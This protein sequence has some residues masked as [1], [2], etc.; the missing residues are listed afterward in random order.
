ML[1]NYL[2]I[3]WRNLWKHKTFSLINIAGLAIGMATSLLILEYV[4]FERSFDSFHTQADKMYRI[5]YNQA[6]DNGTVTTKA[7]TFASV[8][9]GLQNTFPEIKSVVRLHRSRALLAYETKGQTRLF[10]EENILAADPSV[11]TFFSFPLVR[12]NATTSL[13]DPTSIVISQA[14]AQMYFGSENPIGKTL[15]MTGGYGDWTG[16]DYREVSYFTVTGVLAN[17]PANSHLQLDAL[18]SFRLFSRGEKELSNWGDS[19]HT[20]VALH[21]GASAQTLATKLP[22]FVKK[23]LGET[24]KDGL[25]LQPLTDIHLDAAL[26]GDLG[27]NGSRLMVSVLLAIAFFVSLIG[28]INYVNLTTARA[29]E[30][31]KE[32]GIRK[33]TGASGAN[34]FRQF[35]IESLFANGLGIGLAIGLVQL[36]QPLFNELVKQPLSLHLLTNQSWLLV[37]V[38]FFVG[39]MLCSGLYPILLNLT[40][41]PTVVL[42]GQPTAAG[43]GLSLRKGLVVFQFVLSMIL[44]TG[45]LVMYRQVT[46]MQRY[47]VGVNL[48]QLVLDGPE[49]TDSTYQT[50]LRQLKTDLLQLPA[51]KKVTVS[52]LIPGNPISGLSKAGLVRRLGQPNDA[53]SSRYYFSQVD[54]QFQQTYGMRLVAGQWFSP[55]ASSDLTSL[56][57]VVINKTAARLLGYLDPAKAIGQKINYRVQSTPTIIGVLD[58]YHQLSL[59]QS[60]APIIFELGEA[61]DG[62]YTISMNRDQLPRT[63]AAIQQIWRKTFPDSPFS[64]FFLDDFFNRQYQTDWTFARLSSLFALLAILVASL[65]LFGLANLTTRQRTKEIGVRKV[66]GA[67]VTSIVALLSKDFLKLVLIAIVIA[68]PIAWYAMNRWL[69]DFAYKIDIEW[70]VFALAGLLAVG[71]ALL[72]VSFQSVKA[73][74]MNP[75]KSLRSE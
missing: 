15:K 19:F 22:D 71:I 59:K 62:Y 13:L 68:S 65:G 75:V 57:T 6:A 40:V 9:Q 58:D 31:V 17:V 11:L 12:G 3:A 37:C 29:T 34:L 55:T 46:F 50:K 66:L 43:K 14:L 42:R 52:N 1:R 25:Q 72:T 73:A 24:T 4:S 32:V 30:R 7:T 74:L 39:G 2:K 64:Y 54:Y 63:V 49:T 69:Q 56:Q 67:S 5:V 23:T 21:P 70:W 10:R 47:D 44:I 45:S 26:P 33:V 48:N 27:V 60:L 20:Y 16:D 41:Q 38:G 61:P 36:A 18:V 28:W 8:G 35:L 51:V 53:A